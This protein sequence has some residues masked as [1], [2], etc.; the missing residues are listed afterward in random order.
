MSIVSLKQPNY[1][2]TAK[3]ERKV[4]HV[5]EQQFDLGKI[6]DKLYIGESQAFLPVHLT[7]LMGTMQSPL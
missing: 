7:Q 6:Q 1:L 5:L 2:K 3:L 4:M